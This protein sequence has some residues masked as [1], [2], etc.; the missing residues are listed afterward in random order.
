MVCRSF[1][2]EAAASRLGLAMCAVW[3]LDFVGYCVRESVT[4][5]FLHQL[6]A[7]L[8]KFDSYET[9]VAIQFDFISLDKTDHIYFFV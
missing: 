6:V 7:T 3:L 9:L 1:H 4:V 8:F 2:H 5:G